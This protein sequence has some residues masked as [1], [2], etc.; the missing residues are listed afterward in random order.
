MLGK[1]Y[2]GQDC[3]IAR[4]LEVFG[5]RWTLLIVRDAL[6]GVRRFRGL[7]GCTSTSRRRCC[8]TV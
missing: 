2:V 5:E 1:E 6:Y 8:P 3:G 4:A 7:S